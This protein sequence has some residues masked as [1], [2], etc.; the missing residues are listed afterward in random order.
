MPHFA[1][2]HWLAVQPD[3]VRQSSAAA[4]ARIFRSWLVFPDV[5]QL[6][7]HAI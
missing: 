5:A 7:V 2:C 1:A 3:T 6:L 4:P